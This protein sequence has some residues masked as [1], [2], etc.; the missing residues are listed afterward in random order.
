MNRNAF[1]LVFLIYVNGLCAQS[2]QFHFKYLNTGD[3]LSNN[4][5]TAI[6]QDKFGQMWFAT[7]NGLNKYNGKDFL[8]YR[9]EPKN[10]SSISNSEILNILEDT[11]GYIWVGTINGLNRY[12]PQKDTFKRYYK[13][14]SDK[15]SLSHSL[16]ISS[17]DMKNGNIWFGTVNGVSIYNKKR[18]NF[19]RFLYTSNLNKA[20]SVNHIYLDAKKHIWLS[21][22][23]GI[24]KIERTK[25]GKFTTDTFKLNNTESS[26]FFVNNV[27]EISPDIL[28]VATKFNGYLLF[29][30]VSEQ[31]YDSKHTE[32]PKTLDVKD[33]EKD[34]FGNLWLATTNGVF[35]ITPSQEV[36]TL[37]ENRDTNSAI[38]QNYLKSIYKDKNGAMW[39]ATQS[40]GICI[41]DKSNQNF[42]HFYNNK[43][44]NN[45]TNS[46]V[47]DGNKTIYFGTEGGSVHTRD[48]RCK[49]EEL[50]KVQNG[51]KT[52][53]YSIQSM[54]YLKPNLLWIGTLNNG[55]LVYDLKTKTQRNDLISSELMALTENTGVLDIKKDIQ[56]DIWFGTFGK[57]LIKYNVEK[58]EVTLFTRPQLTT[59]II[60][61]IHIDNDGSVFT[62]G[63]GGVNIL[64]P[65]VNNTYKIST[66]FDKNSFLSFNIKT[67]YKDSRGT[68]W[69]GT[70]TRG[71]YKFNGTDFQ[72]VF[73][74]VKNRVSTV[75]KILEGE[76]GML[77]LSTDKGIVRYNPKRNT[78]TIYEQKSIMDSNDFI[79]NSGANIGSQ[80]YFGDLRG[81][82]TFNSKE[83]IENKKVPK[84]L[85]SDLKIKNETV[86]V[87]DDEGILSKSLNYTNVLEL[88]YKNSNFSISYALPDYINSKGNKYAYRLKGLDDEWI[89]TKQTEAFFTLQTPGTYTFEVKGTNYNDVWSK[90]P[91]S[92][93]IIINPA[94]WKT[95]WAYTIY[96]LLFFSA[97]YG[98]IWMLQSK[99]R[100]THKLKLEHL[101][102]KR[103]EELNQAKLRFFTNISH[104][105]RT[106]LTL[107]LGPLQNILNDYSGSNAIYKKL[108]IIDGSANH[109]LRLINR[110]MDFRKLE[111]N[112]LKLEAAEGNIVKFLQEI[113]LSFSEYAKNGKYNYTFNTSHE[114]IEVYYDRYK[115]ERVFYNLISNAFKYT[116]KGGDININIY[117]ED[118]EV[119]IEIQDSG[120]G[121]PEAYLNK[122]FDRFFE[123]PGRN[124]HKEIHNKGTGIGLS[125]ANNIV[126]L[127][128]GTISADNVKPQGAVF[129]VK[130][131]LGIA[132]LSEIEILENFKMSDDVSQYA[133]QIGVPNLETHN[134]PEDFLLEKKKYTIL[135]VEDN[136]I[137]RSFIKEILKPN[138][139]VIQAPNGKVALQKAVE[140][141]PD[142]IISDVIMPEMVGTELCAKIK[143]TL[144]T[145]HIPVILL[146]SRSSLIYKFEG[147]ESGADDYI[148]K[149]FNLKEFNLKIQNLLEFKQRLKEKFSSNENFEALDVSL[150]TLD[151]KLLD[152]AIKVVKENISNQD[153]NI[154]QF[155]E[156]L[157]VSRSMLFTKIKAWTNSTPNDFIQE[158]R[159]K[160]ASKLLEIN[161]L[162]ISE[163]AYEVGFKRPKY[164]SQ[165]FHKKYGLTP[166][167][168]A[169]K[170]ATSSD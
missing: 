97:L 40:K 45:I 71:L 20:T 19:T 2:N 131:K 57:G 58:K 15:T 142:L 61:S 28:G 49:V 153:F 92:L 120:A 63:I 102:S 155:S 119:L 136:T 151:E 132:H 59:N 146:T 68:V 100:L 122:I 144:A 26:N 128:H 106:P 54:L 89:Y 72:K 46:V 65:S 27:I 95:W 129:K 98:I 112:Q 166:S 99:T 77:W 25:Q 148:S 82:T 90:T 62:G 115:L 158:I 114:E 6:K 165:C 41:W 75:Y 73:I 48:E 81:V 37:Q 14:G 124:E 101:E 133:T 103:K 22:N 4:S 138:Y 43:I 161:R 157:G 104:E 107:I 35:I 38:S 50:F 10:K 70:N 31:F 74:A 39:L 117:K 51:S 30:K 139:N 18:D 13:V 109:L 36:I 143:T 56:G 79:S 33:L 137:L 3:G 91:T 60:K 141:L 67:I 118:A 140:H 170:F 121:I 150:T 145:S 5:I 34:D 169:K 11:E 9:N 94:P 23:N 8:V 135:I 83:I 47:S 64:E 164:F 76:N 69:A 168:F 52:I 108:K 127:H 123:V 111:S 130:L 42:V 113:F 110:L 105:F 125:I 12:N 17:L 24:I 32:I 167:E 53:T 134:N 1:F 87:N 126:N 149:P 154:A 16:V 93:T 96:F 147:L 44:D 78:A 85:L 159:L 162:N 160:Y 88:N 116:D 152:K 163:I 86:A 7:N 80:F 84:V 29:D 21:T 156:E 66:F 55:L